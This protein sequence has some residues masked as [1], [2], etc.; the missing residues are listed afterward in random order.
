MSS[1]VERVMLERGDNKPLPHDDRQAALSWDKSTSPDDWCDVRGW[2]QSVTESS[3]IRRSLAA[4][5]Q[6]KTAALE[7]LCQSVAHLK[8]Y[9]EHHLLFY[10]K[11]RKHS[12]TSLA[13]GH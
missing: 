13:H 11:L 1:G 5:E 8:R 10:H 2:H 3:E 7:R 6:S 12:L 4:E 9:L